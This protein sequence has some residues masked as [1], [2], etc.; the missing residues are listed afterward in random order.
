MG[1]IASF[2]KAKTDASTFL[3]ENRK[4]P[5]RSYLGSQEG[6]SRIKTF[7]EF[8]ESPEKILPKLLRKLG[9]QESFSERE[10]KQMQC[11]KCK[12]AAPVEAADEELIDTL[13]AISVVAKR[14]AVKL[15]QQS[16]EKEEK[17]GENEGTT[18]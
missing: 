13:I 14:L 7:H 2:Y 9:R 18:E 4:N 11:D 12:R 17:P 8:H 6:K 10:V 5:S 1:W 16:K 15:R 3:P